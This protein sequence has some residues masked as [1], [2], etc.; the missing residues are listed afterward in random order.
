MLRLQ[1]A[2]ELHHGA[3]PAAAQAKP[4]HHAGPVQTSQKVGLRIQ[5]WGSQT[6]RPHWLHG[7]FGTLFRVNA[8]KSGPE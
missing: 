6:L 5:P 1:A 7:S 8:G 3:D 2:C 4:R